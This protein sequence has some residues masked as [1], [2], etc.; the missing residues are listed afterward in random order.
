MKVLIRVKELIEFP[1]E[2]VKT[3]VDTH[4]AFEKI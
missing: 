4:V 2:A 1:I 3:P